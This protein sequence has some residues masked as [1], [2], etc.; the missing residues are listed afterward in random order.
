[1]YLR[2]TETMHSFVSMTGNFGSVCERPIE[3]PGVWDES[4][5]LFPIVVNASHGLTET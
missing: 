5:S 1:M 2:K 4:V 3:L